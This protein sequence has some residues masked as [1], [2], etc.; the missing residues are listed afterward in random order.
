MGAF[1]RS[2]IGSPIAALVVVVLFLVMYGLIKVDE[3]PPVEDSEQVNIQ[4]GRQ[5]RDTDLTNQ[6]RLERPK[7]D[8]PPPPPPAINNQ[9]FKP[10]VSG[11]PAVAPT[12]QADVNVTSGFNP[13]RDAQPIVRIPPA[14]ADFQ[15]C[16]TSDEARREAVTLEFDV[17]PDGQVTNVKVIDSTDSCYERSA[18]RAAQRWKY[19]PKIVDG[20]PQPRYGVRTTIR[21]EVGGAAQ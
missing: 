13:D 20:E 21:F 4:I 5:I 8:Q 16:I 1:I 6:R 9:S 15:R 7:L 18:T 17:T 10:T 12:L 19:N 3:L 11:V 2:L 14:E